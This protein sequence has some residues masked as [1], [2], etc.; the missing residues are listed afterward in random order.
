MASLQAVNTNS[1]KVGDS[2][3]VY[4]LFGGH[5]RPYYKGVITK[6]TK[7][8]LTVCHQ[9]GSESRFHRATGYIVGYAFPTYE[10]AVAPE[11]SK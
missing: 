8:Y 7:S 11:T 1:R 4:D 10:F 6:L 9:F 5:N 3:Q 2:I